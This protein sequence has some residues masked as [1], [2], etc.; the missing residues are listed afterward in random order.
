MEDKEIK[1]HLR[2]FE[3]ELSSDIDFMARLRQSMDAVEAVRQQSA[4]M[5]RRHKI[6][7]AIAGA[8]GFIMGVLI[9][10]LSPII[11]KWLADAHLS[12]PTGKLTP[13]IYI[14]PAIIGWG[15]AAAVCC[16]VVMNVYE[17]TL[18]K[19]KPKSI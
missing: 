9:T 4:L 7:V 11:D 10:L 5:R 3:P 2:N 6:A 1:A 12:I 19:L 17:L 8:S 13:D 18:A 14:E 15:A 16:I